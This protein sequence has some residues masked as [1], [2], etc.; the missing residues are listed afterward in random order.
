MSQISAMRT[1]IKTIW[2]RV[3]SIT[4]CEDLHEFK[5]V[6][7]QWPVLPRHFSLFSS[8]SNSRLAPGS[9]A[10]VPPRTDQTN[11]EKWNFSSKGITV[12]QLGKPHL[13]LL[14]TSHKIFG[15]SLLQLLV[16]ETQWT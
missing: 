10:Q 16:L 8:D 12:K 9:V 11:P 15:S 3:F 5:I 4:E 7:Y 2:L 1:D 13:S 14:M 6:S